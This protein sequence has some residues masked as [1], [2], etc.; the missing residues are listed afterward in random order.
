L[1]PFDVIVGTWKQAIQAKESM[2]R[3]NTLLVASTGTHINNP[4]NLALDKYVNL[5][6][7]GE[8]TFKDVEVVL[9][10]TQK[11]V[12]NRL[13]ATIYTGQILIIMGPSGSGKTTLARCLVGVLPVVHGSLLI[14]GVSIAHINPQQLAGAIGYLP[15]DVALL[16]G[17]I[18]ENIARFQAL[19]SAEIIAVAKLVGMHEVILRL[20][21][22][23]DTLIDDAGLSLSGGQ[24]QLIG[25]A[26][27]FYQS[28][29]ILVLDE[30]NAH[31]DE[32]GEAHL[33]SALLAFKQMG[34]TV[35]VISHRANL[36]SI[37]DQLLVM[38][39]GEIVHHGATAQ[40]LMQLQQAQT[41]SQAA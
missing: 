38:R 15:Q 21:Q 41:I 12:L 6:I 31:L 26:R 2:Q 19:N 13:N 39:Q 34:K 10:A 17:T 1:Q 40:V 18:A 7:K 28:P 11:R 4:Q 23:Y 25:L 5:N 14:D 9:S 8:I 3:L 30:P 16:D 32:Y 36:L 33:H 20:P 24:R 27:A 22:G 35:V 29:Q 37:A